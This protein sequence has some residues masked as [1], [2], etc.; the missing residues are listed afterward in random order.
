MKSP[1]LS[2]LLFPAALLLADEHVPTNIRAMSDQELSEIHSK[3][4]NEALLDNSGDTIYSQSNYGYYPIVY[5]P[6]SC[7]LMSGISVLGDSIMIEDGS[8]WQV[9]SFDQYEVRYWLENAS[10]VIT[11]NREWFSSYDYR[12]INCDTGTSVT[13]NLLDGPIIDHE[14]SHCIEAID[15][16]QGV[17]VSDPDDLHWAISPRDLDL[18]TNWVPGDYVIIGINSGWDSSYDCILINVATGT[19]VRA[20]QF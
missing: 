4:Q 1:F 14:N 13:V 19:Y 9:S 20:K 2:L 18:I 12:I 17:I 6:I 10:L 15:T 8:A 7:H 5:C 11:Q 3:H 16:I